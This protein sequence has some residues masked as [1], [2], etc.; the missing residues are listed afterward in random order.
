MNMQCVCEVAGKYGIDI[1]DVQI[2]IDKGRMGFQGITGP[3]QLVTLA[4]DAFANEET[5]ARTLYHESVHVSDLRAGMPYP[6]TESATD[7]WESRAYGL[8]NEW[9]ANHPLNSGNLP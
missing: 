1:S 8:E 5:L 6:M 2:T 7:A 4:R 9:W 3:T